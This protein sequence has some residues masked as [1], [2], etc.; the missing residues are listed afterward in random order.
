MTTKKKRTGVLISGRGTNLQALIDAAAKPDF[1]AE[2]SLV[3]SNVA[4]APGL[5][6]AAKAGI[7]TKTIPHRGHGSREAFDKLVDAALREANIELICLAGFMRVLSDSFVRRWEGKLI[8]IHPS[9]L[10]AFKGLD[11]H[12]QVLDAGVT[13]SGCTVHFVVTELDSGPII[14][15]AAVPVF[16]GDDEETLAARTLAAEHKVYPLA[17]GL[18][19]GGH[20][21]LEDGRARFAGMP[22]N[23]GALFNPTP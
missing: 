12:R 5:E 6:R 22:E 9:L 2:I 20:V 1:P 16:T 17:L 4:D 14:A 11:V 13:I 7:A 3:L 18:L 21:K 10:P 23:T 15:Q 8:N 19:A